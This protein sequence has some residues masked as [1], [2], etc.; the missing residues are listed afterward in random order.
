MND[1]CDDLLSVDS[2]QHRES[3]PYGSV[4]ISR[5]SDDAERGVGGVVFHCEERGKARREGRDFEVSFVRSS[6]LI[7]ALSRTA[8]STKVDRRGGG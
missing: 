7:R 3:S 2:S 4:M 8:T 1:S 6:E 5:C